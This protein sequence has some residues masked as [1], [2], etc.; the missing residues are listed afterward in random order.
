M[1]FMKKDFDPLNLMNVQKSICEITGCKI[2]K[3]NTL[4]GVI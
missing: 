2:V 1:S 4:I 3:D